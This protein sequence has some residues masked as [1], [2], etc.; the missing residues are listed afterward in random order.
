MSC[1]TILFLKLQIARSDI[2]WAVS[3][4]IANGQFNF[5]QGLSVGIYEI[6][7]SL[8]HPEDLFVWTSTERAG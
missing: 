6:T 3:L 8:C 1:M 7:Y 2:K 5:P 4:V